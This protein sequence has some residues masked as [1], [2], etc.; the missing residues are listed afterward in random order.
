MQL[1]TKC[2]R[3]QSHRLFI[4]SHNQWQRR[5]KRKATAARVYIYVRLMAFCPALFCPPSLGGL[6]DASEEL[7]WRSGYGRD[8]WSHS[9][10]NSPHASNGGEKKP[11]YFTTINWP[12]LQY[13]GQ[14]FSIWPASSYQVASGETRKKSKWKTRNGGDVRT[15]GPS[16]R[17]HLYTTVFTERP[18]DLWP[19]HP[20]SSIAQH[21]GDTACKEKSIKWLGDGGANGSATLFNRL[22]FN[23]LSP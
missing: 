13:S 4:T 11:T 14:C 19:R 3:Q 1:N 10:I 22:T 6:S 8:W 23:Y 15:S 9:G 17:P 12:Q 7:V 20:Q 21:L 5:D 2:A 16:R 18:H